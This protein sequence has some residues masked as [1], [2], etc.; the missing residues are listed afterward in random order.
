MTHTSSLGLAGPTPLPQ[1]GGHRG[2]LVMAP[3]QPG[4]RTTCHPRIPPARAWLPVVPAT[5]TDLRPEAAGSGR[6]ECRPPHGWKPAPWR[7][8]PTLG[9]VP[10]Q[11]PAFGAL[12]PRA[13]QPAGPR[14]LPLS[15]PGTESSTMSWK[16]T[17]EW[18]SLARSSGVI[19]QRTPDPERGLLRDDGDP[20]TQHCLPREDGDLFAW[21]L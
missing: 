16:S 21:L 8:G 20:E 9:S 13:A 11:T 15:C 5:A 1:M 10:D 17:S 6:W 14:L 2:L 7:Q 19:W 18:A 4:N 3:A 12:R